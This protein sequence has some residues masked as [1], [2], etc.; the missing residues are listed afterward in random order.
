MV[1]EQKNVLVAFVV[2]IFTLG[3]QLMGMYGIM[4]PTLVAVICS[5]M[6]LLG[7]CDV[8]VPPFAYT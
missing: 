3:I 8:C 5:G 4:M 1:V 7:K 2:A 6:T